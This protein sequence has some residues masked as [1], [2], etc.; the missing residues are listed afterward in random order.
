MAVDRQNRR[1]FSFGRR[2]TKGRGISAQ[3]IP[4]TL[5]LHLDA[6]SIQDEA[7]DVGIISAKATGNVD[8]GIVAPFTNRRAQDGEDMMEDGDTMEDGDDTETTQERDCGWYPADVCQYCTDCDEDGNYC[9][10]FDDEKCLGS[11][12]DMCSPERMPQELVNVQEYFGAYFEYVGCPRT[13]FDDGYVASLGMAYCEYFQCVADGGECDDV[14]MDTVCKEMVAVCKE[15]HAFSCFWTQ[16]PEDDP[17]C[18]EV[19]KECEWEVDE[20][21]SASN[22]VTSKVALATVAVAAG[23]N[24]II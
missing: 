17:P 23:R 9:L 8:T 18:V 22:Q 1:R 20:D 4:S 6:D 24:W 15:E 5:D 19:A 21:P 16:T 14:F 13:D 10:D 7:P 3:Q 12:L 2:L 11:L